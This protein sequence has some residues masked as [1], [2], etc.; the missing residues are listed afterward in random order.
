MIDRL[1]LLAVNLATEG[2]VRYREREVA[3]RDL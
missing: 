1:R 2:V 3:D